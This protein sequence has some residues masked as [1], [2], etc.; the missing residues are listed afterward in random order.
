VLREIAAGRLRGRALRRAA[1]ELLATQASDWAFLDYRR[2]A[3][4]Y[5]FRR[6]V[7]HSRALFES[8]DSD[9]EVEPGM[10]NLAPDLSPAPLLE[11]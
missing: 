6:M 7:D 10:R 1:R 5:P 3:G 2:Q 11:P 4:D 8:I 9:E